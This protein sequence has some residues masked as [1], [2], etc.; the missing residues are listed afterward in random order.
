MNNQKQIAKRYKHLHGKKWEVF[1]GRVPCQYK[2]AEYELSLEEKKNEFGVYTKVVV[3]VTKTHFNGR[4]LKVFPKI[5]SDEL[6]YNYVR[7]FKILEDDIEGIEEHEM[8]TCSSCSEEIITLGTDCDMYS[9][10]WCDECGGVAQCSEC[11]HIIA[12]QEMNYN[13]SGDEG[14]C[15]DCNPDEEE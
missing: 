5:L 6:K 4:I 1:I 7:E 10:Y 8:A 11:G 14:Y 12:G 3:E 2:H 15:D 9:Q 13:L